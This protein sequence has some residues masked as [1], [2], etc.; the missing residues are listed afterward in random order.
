M[1]KSKKS[2]G[3][4][5]QNFY[6]WAVNIFRYDGLLAL[7]WR[8]TCK[9]FRPLGI[10]GLVTIFERDLDQPIQ[11]IKAK[12]DLTIAPAEKSEIESIIK[13]VEARDSNGQK[14]KV[15][16]IILNRFQK[17]SLCFLGKIGTEVVHY[18]WISFN[19][20]ESLAGRFLH[21]K[22]NEAFF[23]DAFTLEKWR[24][25]KIYPAVQYQ[26]F[27]Y[28]KQRGYRKIYTLVDTDNRSSK[29]THYFHGWQT[30]GLVLYFTPRGAT[31]GWV[32]RIRGTVAPFLEKQ[33]P[34]Q[35]MKS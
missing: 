2:I 31:E 11:E 27:H 15:Q 33:I 34:N 32:W 1:E 25:E 5:L 21:L 9:S 4:R 20:D 3:I 22:E 10:L 12:V 29:K 6:R 26:L 8:L 14:A 30:I 24:G 17:G 23:L 28:L 7:F 18:N 16:N 19:W 35:V 13:L